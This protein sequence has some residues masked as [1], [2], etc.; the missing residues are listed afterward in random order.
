[1]HAIYG[2]SKTSVPML[3]MNRRGKLFLL[4]VGIVVAILGFLYSRR[5]TVL[6]VKNTRNT[7]LLKGAVERIF[8]EITEKETV[9]NDQLNYL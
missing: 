2:L 8:L 5:E 9:S 6:V 3:S 7:P 1:M 4:L